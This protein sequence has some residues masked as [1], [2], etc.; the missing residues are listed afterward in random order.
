MLCRDT[1]GQE[2]FNALDSIFYRG[3]NM[4]LLVYDMTSV[5]SFESLP[6]WYDEFLSKSTHIDKSFPFATIGINTTHIY[7]YIP[8]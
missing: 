2:R 8:M 5:S 1:A 6:L 4:C 7:I 3:A